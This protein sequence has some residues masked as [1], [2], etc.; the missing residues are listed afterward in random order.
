M[1]N[2]E[3]AFYVGATFGQF[4]IFRIVAALFAFYFIVKVVDKLALTP[5][6]EY[7]R[8]KIYRNKNNGTKKYK[9]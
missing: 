9:N 4:L 8:N 1:N 5:L 2:P 3:C 7:L 6:L